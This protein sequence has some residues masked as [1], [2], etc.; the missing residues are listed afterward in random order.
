MGWSAE[1][2]QDGRQ[3]VGTV[4]PVGQLHVAVNADVNS[5][6]LAHDVCFFFFSSLN[7]TNQLVPWSQREQI[8]EL[9]I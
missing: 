6:E 5:L 3:K 2:A 7:F 1:V 9:T 8:Q 4:W